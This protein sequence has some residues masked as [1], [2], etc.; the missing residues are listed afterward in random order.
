M[1][2]NSA[3]LGIKT[4]RTRK[5]AGVDAVSK[6]SRRDFLKLAALAP[7]AMAF[8][9]VAPD[10]LSAGSQQ[11]GPLSNV[12]IIEFDAMTARDM[13]LYGF[14]RETTPN[15]KRFAER[16]TVYHAHHSGGNC[17]TPSV[18]SLLTGMYPWTHRAINLGGLIMR[19]LA[20][21]NLFGIF[22]KEYTRLAFSHN[23]LANQL[24]NQLHT[25]IDI[26]LP[27]G[28]F[29]VIDGMV[30]S[31]FNDL[32]ATYQAY[33]DF[34]FQLNNIPASFIF[35]L[36]ERFYITRKVR[37]ARAKDYPR[38]LP[39][40]FSYPIYFRLDDLFDGMIEQSTRLTPP[41]IA[42]FHILPPHGNYNP[43]IKFYY[44][45]RKDEWK[46][47]EKPTH[48]FAKFAENYPYES[49]IHTR[50]LYDAYVANVDEEFG[51]LLD[52][53]NEAGILDQSY[54]I[55]TSDHGESFERGEKG[56]G[57]RLMYEPV[58]HIP[59]VISTPGQST[60]KDVYS[61]TS[62]VD[63]L[64]TLLHIAGRKVPDWCEGELLPGLGGEEN[65]GRID[66]SMQAQ[67]NP[68]F[69]PLTT[70]TLAMRKGKYKMIYYTGYE[71][72][73]AFEL[74][75]LE[76]DPEEL[77]DLYLEERWIAASIREELLAKLQAVN[78]P[79]QNL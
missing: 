39:V 5:I 56:H 70:L 26:H 2:Y 41:Y 43:H 49:L 42:F 16:A 9:R 3:V 4:G 12:I 28:S 67:E 21:R 64:P 65:A 11:N 35:G 10:L 31:H 58:L 20:W 61:P 62:N 32:N 44:R 63:I 27:P 23:I 79:Y 33:D 78:Q 15:I 29:S 25:D 57:T 34:L 30:G 59:L 45:F 19:S 68:A 24:L 1:G 18:A 69:F 6:L 73:D 14:P 37:G 46:P 53:F 13:S 40:S 72:N 36:I 8:Y 50:R 55:V 74:Y 48:R 60:R 47:V 52:A 77:N 71:E 54:V 75:N 38:G 51:R 7:A 66:F 76:N 17:T 22:G